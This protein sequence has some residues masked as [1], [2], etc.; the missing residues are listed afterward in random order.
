METIDISQIKVLSTDLDDTLL[1][2][3]LS[4]HKYDIEMLKKVQECGM[5]L[6]FSSGLLLKNTCFYIVIFI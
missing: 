5:N 2:K 3:N 4:V 1:R 6:V